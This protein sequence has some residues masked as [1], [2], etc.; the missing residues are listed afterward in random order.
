MPSFHTKTIELILDPVA[1]QVS[2]LVILH[3]ASEDGSAMP[4]LSQQIAVVS[5]AVQNLVRVGRETTNSSKDTVLKQDMP[6]ALNKVE[7]ASNGLLQASLMLRDDPYSVS[8]RKTLIEGSRGILS[9]TAQLLLVFDQAE[10]RKI[11]K[12][13]QGVLDY[14]VVAEVIEG[15]QDLVTFV[16]NLTPGMTA[17][18]NMVSARAKELTFQI[19]RELLEKHLDSVKSMVPLLVSAIKITVTTISQGG[20]G[21]K[22]AHE[23]RNYVIKKMCY[24]IREI[25]RVLQLTTY[26][27]DD[28]AMDD[29]T[30]LKKAQ[31][32]IASQMNRAQEWLSDPNAAPGG[33]G[34]SALRQ[35]LAD[36]RKV[37]DRVNEPY[38]RN[39]RGA[40]DELTQL[41]DRLAELRAKGLGNTPEAQ[42]LSNAI[43]AKLVALQKLV[44]T[45]VQDAVRNGTGKPAST[46]TGKMEQ[47]QAWLANPLINDKGVGREAIKGL[48]KE[49]RKVAQSLSG[50]ERKELEALCDDV[51]TLYSQLDALIRK[52]MGNSP[53]AQA[54]KQQLAQKLQ[55]L[56]QK[57]EKALATQVVDT[58]MDP[59]GPLNHLE[60]AAKAPA[61]EPNRERTYESKATI[62]L[63]HGKQMADTAKSVAEAGSCPDKKVVGELNATA[64]DVAEMT[65][66]LVFAGKLVLINPG[67]AA[68]TENFDKLRDKYKEKVDSLTG[69]VDEATDAVE[70]IKASEESIK[71]DSEEVASA[72]RERNSANIVLKGGNIARKAR[73]IVTVANKEADNSE[74]PEFVNNVKD[75]T[76]KLDKSTADTVRSAKAISMNPTDSAAQNNW[77][78]S[79]GELLID[80]ERVKRP[81]IVIIPVEQQQPPPVA[82]PIRSSQQANLEQAP[83][84]SRNLYTASSPQYQPS[85]SSSASPYASQSEGV[86]ASPIQGDVFARPQ[87]VGSA[88]R[89]SEYG[90]PVPPPPAFEQASPK[91]PP[92]PAPTY[93][94]PSVTSDHPSAASSRLPGTPYQQAQ[95][96]QLQEDVATVRNV[97]QVN[98]EP[99][100]PPPPDLSALSISQEESAP[101]RPPL[102]QGQM[103]PPRPPPPEEEE[104]I[105]F[106]K[107]QTDEPIMKAAYDLHVEAQK[108]SS[109]GN[110]L[111]AA[112]K[113]MALLMAQMS[114]YVRGEGGS[115]KGL[116][117]CAKAIAKASDE[118]TRLA[119][120][121]ARQCTDKRIRMNLMQVC[122]RIP[123][124]ATQLKIISTVKATLLGEP[125]AE[126]EEEATEVLVLNA[127]NLMG[128]VKETVRQAEAASIKIRTEA[129]VK[130]RWVRKSPWY[131]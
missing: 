71:Q 126:D 24:D 32:N 124:I 1:Q 40:V 68:A 78:K 53:E 102:P 79:N 47:A 31:D 67:N 96:S 77:F 35:I 89:P 99:P 110:D 127:Q 80:I 123:T 46:L 85:G 82:M 112:A 27:E 103:P 17:M 120:E 97:M 4:D 36:S 118:V 23:N 130:M 75:A 107:P 125:D 64:N 29:I 15:M 98:K 13:C 81:L 2:E 101:P 9:G 119:T 73:R 8:A 42:Q 38:A 50:P 121:I 55:A 70:F 60:K 129:G 48:V 69:L 65:P 95:P 6:P 111:I 41:T 44:D 116:I 16:K 91:K 74:D 83:P 52:G 92:Q 11:L 10:V 57:I 59:L 61:D 58:F 18:A 49:G 26:D 37:A 19:H 63:R 122:E 88:S 28:W 33:I 108:W 86:K 14:I 62:F 117:D 34:E 20:A 54:I 5:A 90:P 56:Q 7:E 39:I 66:Q 93:V 113:K 100:L 12:H 45:A 115:K 30:V 84:P 25:M 3:E 87:Y 94:A 22:E 109:K 114:K 128:A 131:S 43:N 51:E 104:E 106:P 21:L 105:N 72:I 76:K